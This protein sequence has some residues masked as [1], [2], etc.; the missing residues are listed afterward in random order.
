MIGRRRKGVFLSY[1]F[2]IVVLV[3]D[4][5]NANCLALIQTRFTRP[6]SVEIGKRYLCST[7]LGLIASFVR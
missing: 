6:P 2:V 7:A 3:A 5:I 1:W 4:V